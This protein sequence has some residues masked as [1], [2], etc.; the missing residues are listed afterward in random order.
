LAVAPGGSVGGDG[1]VP[2]FSARL[3]QSSDSHIL[4]VPTTQQHQDLAENA[5][6]LQAVGHIIST[7]AMPA[8]ASLNAPDQTYAH[9]AMASRGEVAQVL[10]AAGNNALPAGDP[11]LNAAHMQRGILREFLK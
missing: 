8:A 5:R 1:T 6:V 9:P 7:G 3:A 11:R 4:T 2:A 10:T